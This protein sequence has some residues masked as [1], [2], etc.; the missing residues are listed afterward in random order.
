MSD[1]VL[2]QAGSDLM[3]RLSE[4]ASGLADFWEK[5][6]DAVKRTAMGMGSGAVIGGGAALALNRDNESGITPLRAAAMGALTGGAG[7]L[8]LQALTGKLRLPGES[9]STNGPLS[10]LMDAGTRAVTGNPLTTAGLVGGGLWAA[11]FGPTRRNLANKVR[12][13]A[14]T[15]NQARPDRTFRQGAENIVREMRDRAG[16]R[17]A[18]RV[19]RSIN[20]LSEAQRTPK[21]L[22]D[23]MEKHVEDLV[24]RT[25]KEVPEGA[26]PR[27]P[28]VVEQQ[29]RIKKAKEVLEDMLRRD[30]SSNNMNEGVTRTFFDPLADTGELRRLLRHD[31]DSRAHYLAPVIGGGL[32]SAT[33][34]FLGGSD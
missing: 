11:K 18:D 12:A 34:E 17:A 20:G 15:A 4:G 5:Q 26:A 8:G 2:K 30:R 25:L 14:A 33:E 9:Q 28:R 29:Q 16:S 10:W 32:G 1:T 21:N 19:G 24:A 31:A 22:R 27:A 6:P 23:I 3:D 13:M 7:S